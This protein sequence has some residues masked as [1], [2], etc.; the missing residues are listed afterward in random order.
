MIGAAKPIIERRGD[1]LR[2][3]VITD[4][5]SDELANLVNSSGAD[6]IEL[7][8]SKGTWADG[9]AFLSQVPSLKHLI[10]LDL[11]E[12]GVSPIE[13]LSRLESLK[14]SA[15]ATSPLDF[16][17]LKQLQKAFV[18]W[19]K[20]YRN[21]SALSNLQDL[22][23]NR[24]TERDLAALQSLTKLQSLRIGD[25]PTDQFGVG[26]FDESCGYCIRRSPTQV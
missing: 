13:G 8:S 22:Y 10:I 5:W 19:R 12:R 23:L 7:N 18:E 25:S 16:A 26:C 6:G 9:L 17:H 4:G 2:W 15:Y 11:Q 1:G 14:L 3:L 21:I 24:Y 20:Q